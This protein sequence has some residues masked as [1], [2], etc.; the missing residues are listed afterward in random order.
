MAQC[1]HGFVF[2]NSL[3][4]ERVSK[5]AL[6]LL[7]LLA[8]CKVLGCCGV[9]LGVSPLQGWL[10]PGRADEQSW[11]CSLSRV[12]VPHSLLGRE[13]KPTLAAGLSDPR[14][15][16]N[17]TTGI[18]FSQGS[19]LSLAAEMLEMFALAAARR[20]PNAE[21]SRGSCWEGLWLLGGSS[22]P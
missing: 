19:S 21:E 14:D 17:V 1:L 15:G 12:F 8:V 5:G 18:C 20:K 11:S 22:S 3:S 7:N 13:L 2:L 10:G 9:P 4:G 6:I 16:W